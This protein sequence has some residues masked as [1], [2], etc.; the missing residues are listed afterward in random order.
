MRPPW[1]DPARSASRRRR[2]HDTQQSDTRLPGAVGRWRWAVSAGAWASGRWG[3]GRFRAPRFAPKSTRRTIAGKRVSENNAR[4]R[5]PIADP[6][7]SEADKYTGSAGPAPS[8]R[9]TCTGAGFPGHSRHRGAWGPP[10]PTTSRTS[11]RCGR[12]HRGHGVKRLRQVVARLRHHLRGG[13]AALRVVAR[14]TRASS[15]GGWRKPD[16]DGI[17]GISQAIAIARRTHHRNPGPRSGRRPRFTTTAAVVRQ[18][19]AHRIASAVRTRCDRDGRISDPRLQAL[20]RHTRVM[21]GF[22]CRW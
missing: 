20:P 17:E 22:A 13:A 12:Q 2:E 4:S 7:A 5:H 1:Q 14:P 10:H 9:T 8:A 3:L 11:S 21:V 18:S 16:V 15:P 19:R 6:R